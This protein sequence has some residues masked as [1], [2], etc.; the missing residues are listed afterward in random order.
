MTATV[1]WE[2]Q[3]SRGS[4]LAVWSKREGAGQEQM[5][6]VSFLECH[7]EDSSVTHLMGVTDGVGLKLG[8]ICRRASSVPHGGVRVTGSAKWG[9][10]AGQSQGDL[11]GPLAEVYRGH[12]QWETV[13]WRQLARIWVWGNHFTSH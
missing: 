11:R 6:G 7:R 3:E 10:E 1:L 8:Q 5:V 12:R 9:W 4:G 13:V 2:L